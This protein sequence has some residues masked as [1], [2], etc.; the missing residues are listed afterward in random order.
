MKQIHLIIATNS[1]YT[2]HVVKEVYLNLNNAQKRL[3]QLP[4][5]DY[6]RYYIESYDIADSG[7][8]NV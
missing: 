3:E 2:T 4:R 8:L 6:T 1:G 5:N 7:E